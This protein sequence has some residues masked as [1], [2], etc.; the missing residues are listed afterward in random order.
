MQC[1]SLGGHL[2]KL[3]SSVLQASLRVP[4]PWLIALYPLTTVGHRHDYLPGPVSPPNESL[5]RGWS[6]GPI[7]TQ[8]IKE[9]RL[10]P[11]FT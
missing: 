7:N 9:R 4:N 5:S 11:F 2:G 1:E 8:G 6:W 3:V 10:T